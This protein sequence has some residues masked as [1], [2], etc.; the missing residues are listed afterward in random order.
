MAGAPM[1]GRQANQRLEHPDVSV[2]PAELLER[3]SGTLRHE[4]GPAVEEEYTRT[5]TFMA[6]VILAKLAKQLALAPAH[7]DAERLDVQELH[8][9]F[10][11]VL[12]TAPDEVVAAAAAAKEAGTVAALSPVIEAIYRCWADE[13][14]RQQALS[15][16][17]A[18]LRRDIDR[19]MEIAT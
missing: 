14:D 18:T 4:V 17:R 7:G 6:S 5:Q 10:G 3:L 13:A 11:E 12:S 9:A 16:I 1:V 15:L 8:R 19:R 2:E